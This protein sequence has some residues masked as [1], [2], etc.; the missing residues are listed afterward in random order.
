MREITVK[1]YQYAEL[2]A[3][4]Q[5]KARDW[6]RAGAEFDPEM[7]WYETAAGILGI[8]F[9]TSIT[10][11]VTG[12]PLVY[13]DIRYSGFYSQGDGAS[14]VGTYEYAKGCAKAI[15]TEFPM[16][17]TLHGIADRLT[18]LQSAVKGFRVRARIT[19]SGRYSHSHTMRL[20]LY[21]VPDSVTEDAYS[22]LE[23]NLLATM[24]DF[25]DWIYRSLEAD[26]ENERSDEYVAD[27]IEANEYE[28]CASGKMP[29]GC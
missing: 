16:D 2:N 3:A 15:R 10:Q 22:E 6:Y 29:S 25:A 14:F 26:Y 7:E 24:R 1:L 8:T 19:Q 5:A 23:T 27:I 18:A 13:P 28:F 17:T 4:A 21:D 11:S 12:K 9:G 20:E